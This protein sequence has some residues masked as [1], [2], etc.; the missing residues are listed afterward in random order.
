[1]DT[2]KLP[3]LGYF[4]N[5][6]GWLGSAGLLRFQLENSTPKRES[7]RAEGQVY[8]LTTVLW[9]G[10]FSRPYAR[11]LDQRETFPISDAGIAALVDYLARQAE[12]LNAAP[13]YTPEETT[14]YYHQK[15]AEEKE[16]SQQSEV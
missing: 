16:P 6:N 15:K 2:I 3:T 11:E 1:M 7:D 14:A 10:P 5:G 12:A 8:E 4:K 13:P 9:Q